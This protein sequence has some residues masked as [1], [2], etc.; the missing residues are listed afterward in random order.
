M[1][2]HSNPGWGPGG[3]GPGKAPTAAIVSRV[4]PTK[5]WAP[6][7]PVSPKNTDAN[8]PSLVLKPTWAYSMNCVS[9]NAVPSRIV[10]TRPACRPRRLLRLTDWSAQCIVK[11]EV[12]RIAVLMPATNFGN[13]NGCGGQTAGA[14]GLTTRTKK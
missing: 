4:R 1:P 3:E 12:T 13:S 2:G 9:G 7:S 11:L 6:W 14:S 5:T 8:E 10:R